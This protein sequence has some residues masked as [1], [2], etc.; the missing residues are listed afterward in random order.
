MSHGLFKEYGVNAVTNTNMVNFCELPMCEKRAVAFYQEKGILPA[1][2]VCPRGH[3]MKLYFGERIQWWC[4]LRSCRAKVNMR[5]GNW[6]QGSRLPFLTSLRF[7]YY[8]TQRTTTTDWC[9]R[10]LSMANSTTVEWNNY[11]REVCTYAVE[12]RSTRKIG[13]EDLIVQV[14]ESVFSKRKNNDG[15][16]F[17]Q[18][19]VFGG[20][21][22]ETNDCFLVQVPDRSLKTITSVITKHI[23]EGSIIY[24][25]SWSSACVSTLSQ[26]LI[27]NDH[28]YKFIDSEIVNHT[29]GITERLWGSI[30]WRNKKYR[31]TRHHLDYSYLAEFMWRWQLGN[32]DAFE[33]ITRCIKTFWPPDTELIW[34]Q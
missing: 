13:G 1:K 5:I 19:C 31:G 28:R 30:L 22:R 7:I 10:H 26:N 2:R 12:L 4:N 14:D 18:Q 25:D 27:I 24:S 3:D 33:A 16:I 9:H 15:H 23:A 29:A 34:F 8:W 11:L 17:P 32:T 21:C 20:I 6:F